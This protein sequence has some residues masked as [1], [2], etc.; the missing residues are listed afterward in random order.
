M[1]LDQQILLALNSWTNHSQALDWFFIFCAN[2]L[3]YIFSAMAILYWFIHKPENKM[4]ERKAVATAFISFVIARLLLTELIRIIVPRHRPIVLHPIID[5]MQIQK[6]SAFP[7]GHASAM[8]AIAIAIYFYNKRLGSWL[9]VMSAVTAVARVV[10]GV[11]WPSDIIAGALLGILVAWLTEK[12]LAGKINS[13]LK[14]ISEASDRFFA[15][16][17]RS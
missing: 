5:L 1:N 11:H 15:F 12:F 4:L 14:K 16:T 6:E 8:F 10:I 7:S 9:L 3:V 13:L 2:Y 17:D